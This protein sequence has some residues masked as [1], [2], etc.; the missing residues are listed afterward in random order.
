MIK[1]ILKL[2][3]GLLLGCII[4]IAFAAI[5]VVLFTDLSLSDYLLKLRNIE[6]GEGILS[7]LVAIAA[8]LISLPIQV[9][10]HEGGH[11]VCG[12]M[13]GYQFVSFRIFN[14]TFI[15]KDGKLI[16]KK[17]AVAGTGGQ[18]LLSPPERK[19]EEIPV[20]WYN[21]GGVLANVIAVLA[22]LPLLWVVN[23]PFLYEVIF[24]F[25]SWYTYEN[26]WNKQ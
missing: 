8:L 14:F 12:L 2:I 23:N 10:L 18:C 19:L 15:R 17:Y 4:G 25:F 13:S 16:I 11:L 26:G 3:G 21:L 20:V 5:I 9:I 24:I 7:A 22:V 6:L 1:H